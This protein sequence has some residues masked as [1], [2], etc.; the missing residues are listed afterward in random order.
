[1]LAAMPNR[2]CDASRFA[3]RRPRRQLLGRTHRG[4]LF[5]A[6]AAAVAAW[7]A[8][9][10]AGQVSGSQACTPEAAPA[11]VGQLVRVCR[12]AADLND[13]LRST[14]TGRVVIPRD[15]RWEMKGRDGQPLA[16]IPVRSGIELVGE[17]GA[18]GSRPL[19]Y[20]D[21]RAEGYPLFVIEDNDVRV[22]G[23]H[24]RGPYRPGDRKKELPAIHGITVIQD[25]ATGRGRR[26]VISG[27][28]IEGFNSAVEIAG[29]IH[30]DYPADY[31]QACEPRPC[32]HPEPGDAALVRVERNYIHNNAMQG[33]GYG[34]VVDGGGYATVEGNVFA[35][36]NHSVA[37][38][39]GAYSGYVARFNYVL[40]GVLTFGSDDTY[41][42][43]FDVHGRGQAGEGK[44]QG[45][46][47]GTYFDVSF[48][49]VLGEQDY[50]FLGRLT[51]AA[52]ALRGR[53]AQ[54][55]QFAGN[56][57]AHDD[58]DEAVKLRAGNDDG[59][60]EDRPG[61]FNLHSG[62]NRYDTDYSTELATGDFDGDGRTD[63]FVA[64]GT[65]WFYSRA[66]IRPWEYLRPSNKRVG[67]LA[68][69]DIDNDGVTD[70]LYR[71]PAGRLGYVKSGTAAPV[72]PLTYLPVAI[73]DLRFGDF[74]GDRLT[75]MFYTRRKQWQV[76]Y[77]GTRTW[78]PR[79]TSDRPISGLL[80]G[81]VDAVR[82]TDVVGIN[83]GGWSY[84]SAATQRWARLNDRLTSSF[85]KA[86]AADF[87]GN[88]R[89]DIAIG[90]G[91]KWRYSRDGRSPLG[92]LRNGNVALTYGALNRL[93]IGRFDGGPR[94]KVI[95]FSLTP[96][97]SPGNIR[98]SPGEWL[99]IWH[100]LGSHGDFSLRSTQAMR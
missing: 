48:N 34:V 4:V 30:S 88:G 92:V 39:G 7:L 97:G 85:S 38:G 69:A 46:P 43:S 87:D 82:G 44:F 37:A 28:E 36:N 3:V 23:L 58:F 35:F 89:T 94:H 59:L 27:N 10:A 91:Q 73:R 71:D 78:T 14:Y 99:V 61:T 79:Q 18:L 32:P 15:A 16:Y 29:T 67:E 64:N 63:I 49:A 93:P 21:Y 66:G 80:F 31:D 83:A 72:T 52:F 1:M 22:E 13:L 54:G 81:E 25:A 17:R 65:A 50:G 96:Y 40:R 26:I 100:G 90:D 24:L 47:A 62:G 2:E 6:L 68:F 12:S 60:D 70:V 11:Q 9:G 33:G 5:L 86:V 84:S 98:Y 51:R 56:V 57:L 42:H 19:L 53:P 74:D 41:P 20:T 95:S 76:W 77:G 55:A 45:G 8:P 75:D